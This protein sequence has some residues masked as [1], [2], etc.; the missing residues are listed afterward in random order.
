M[1]E[2]LDTEMGRLLKSVDLKNTVVIYIGDNGTPAAQK[3]EGAKVRSSKTFVYEGGARV[4]M[5]I[6]GAGVTRKGREPALVN[7][8]DLFATVASLAGIPVTHVYD[9]Y[10]VVPMLT[11]AGASNGRNFSL[12]EFCSARAQRVAIRDRQYKLLYDNT[13]G[14]GLFD[15]VEDIGETK[16]VYG[17]PAY[18]PAQT[19]L[20]AELD[21]M[22][23]TAT[24]G[25]FQ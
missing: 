22:K 24:K 1:I 3:D 12:T 19:R 23:S 2:A 20:K 14:W 25:C 7:G 11:K 5:V 16:N 21:R 6:S 18:L 17:K 9:S 13:D 8:V 10:S 15:L 4:S